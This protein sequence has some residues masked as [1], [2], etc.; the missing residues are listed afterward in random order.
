MGKLLSRWIL[1]LLGWKITGY[2]E[3]PPKKILIAVG[4][5]TSAWDFPLGL[6]T[7]SALGVDIR[8]LGKHT[9][10]R[11]PL[12]W[13][14]RWLGG[15]PVDRT[16]RGNLVDAVVDIFNAKENF[17][18]SIA[19]E[20]T[21]QKVDRLKTGFWWMAKKAGV[22]ILVCRFDFGNR[23]VAFGPLIT[24]G[25]DLEADVKTITDLFRSVRGK[26]P[27]LGLPPA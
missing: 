13:L 2:P 1:K 27:E 26:R 25:E 10:F 18:I 5:H 12:G 16:R 17:I 4:P 7:R 14:F 3:H 23:T 8:F 22:P 6:L 15:Y 21:R 11:P 24:P 9:L 19:P 20:G